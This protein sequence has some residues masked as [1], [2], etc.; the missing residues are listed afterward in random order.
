VGKRKGV[1]G[2]KEPEKKGKDFFLSV[3]LMRF[4]RSYAAQVN[5][6]R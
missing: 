2:I 6:A 1:K 5:G 4:Q 3:S